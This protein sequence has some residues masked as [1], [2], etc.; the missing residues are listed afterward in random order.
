[1]IIPC[2]LT[3]SVIRAPKAKFYDATSFEAGTAFL[4]FTF[5]LPA[6]LATEKSLNFVT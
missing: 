3:T 6:D 5:P 4:A 1:M 2:I